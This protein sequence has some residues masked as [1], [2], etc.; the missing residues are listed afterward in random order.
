LDRHTTHIQI[1]PFG[2]VRQF[3]HPIM[4]CLWAVVVLCTR[5]SSVSTGV[6]NDVTSVPSYAVTANTDLSNIQVL[7]ADADTPSQSF[8]ALKAVL[9]CPSSDD[10][11]RPAEPA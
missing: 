6:V 11:G 2:D 5:G 8:G 10:E 7:R 1:K 4:A 3:S 9:M